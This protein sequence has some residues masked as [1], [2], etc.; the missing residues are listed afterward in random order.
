VESVTAKQGRTS[1]SYYS[2]EGKVEQLRNGVMRRGTWRVSNS[3]RICLQM[4]N[5]QEK[6]RI[7]VKEGNEYKKYIVKKNGD[8]QHSVS[9]R[10]FMQ[11]KQ[12]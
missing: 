6:C 8:H 12:F 7:I 3:A 9:Y 2:P 1:L 5:L 4:E 10:K 11:G